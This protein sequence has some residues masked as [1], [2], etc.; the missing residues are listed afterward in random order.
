MLPSQIDTQIKCPFN[1]QVCGPSQSG[2]S[3]WV[4]KLIQYQHLM[5]EE[6]FEKIF[7]FTPHGHVP[8]IIHNIQNLLVYKCLPWEVKNIDLKNNPKNEHCLIVIDDF[9]L[10]TKNSAELTELFTRFSHHNNMSIIQIT[11]NV[12]WAGTDSRTRSLNVHYMVLLRQLR[13]QKQ[14]RLLARQV[15]QNT[16]QFNAILTAY[17][18]ATEGRYSYLFI[19]FHPRDSPKLLL[20]SKIFPDEGPHTVYVF[21][22]S[23]NKDTAK[24]HPIKPIDSVAYHDNVISAKKVKSE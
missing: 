23:I 11:Q 1:M 12:F 17:N 9:A 21:K 19:S 15:S 13:D 14:I 4:A 8:K 6:G 5:L 10:Q 3:E 7:W 18:D 2:K 24:I 22:N 16:N 20:R